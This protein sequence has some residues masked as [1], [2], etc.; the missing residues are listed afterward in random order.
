MTLS[1]P[2]VPFRSIDLSLRHV[3]ATWP[4]H[5]GCDPDARGRRRGSRHLSQGAAKLSGKRRGRGGTEI[6]TQ[7]AARMQ[8]CGRER[9]NADAY[10]ME[11][12]TWPTDRHLILPEL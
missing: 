4:G 9:L 10:F 8:M 12:N 5:Y 6:N 1:I 11:K 7:R 3:R 2:V